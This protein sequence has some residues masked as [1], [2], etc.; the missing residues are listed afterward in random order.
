MID[1][2]YFFA[3][4]TDICNIFHEIERQF[5]IKYCMTE[6]DR[7]AGRGV[8]EDT[9]GPGRKGTGAGAFALGE[10]GEGSLSGRAVV[11]EEG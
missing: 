8:S 1:T 10:Q 9:A 11:K 2:I 7:E 5:D 6:A 3:S 4:K